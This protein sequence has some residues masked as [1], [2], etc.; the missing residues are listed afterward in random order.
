MSYLIKDLPEEEKPREKAISSGIDTLSIVDLLSI[1]LRTGSKNESVKDLS[2]RLLNKLNGVEGLKNLR[3]PMLTEIKGIGKT[4]AI[5][6]LAAIE[7]GKRMNLTSPP[8]KIKITKT[9]DVYDYYHHLFKEDTQEKFLVLFLNT[10]NYV[11]NEKIIFIG[12]A[13][14]SLVHPRDIFKEAILNNALKI[15]CVHNHP[16]GDVT[17]SKSDIIVTQNLKE[18]GVILGIPLLDHIILGKDSY[19]SFLERNSELFK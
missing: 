10:K 16:T 13:N 4:K 5:T 3:L 2:I 11:I 19:Y 9:K 15:I 14:Q 8:L 7:L 6:L 17:P 12:T 18:V 1:I